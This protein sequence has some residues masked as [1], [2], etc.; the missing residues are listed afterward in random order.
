MKKHPF[1]FK[2]LIFGEISMFIL[3]CFSSLSSVGLNVNPSNQINEIEGNSDYWHIYGC[4][5]DL[6]GHKLEKVTVWISTYD[7][8]W[9]TKTD[10]DGFYEFTKIPKAVPS[11]T[12][13]SMLFEKKGY[14]GRNKIILGTMNDDE[15]E[16]NAILVKYIFDRAIDHPS[17]DR[18]PLLEKLLN[19]I[20]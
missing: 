5:W 11:W 6:L 19:F 18:Y 7:F 15:I 9:F 16:I 12:W 17:F 13:Y 14:F 1:L 4:A 3:V 20:R 2:I 10:S 8:T